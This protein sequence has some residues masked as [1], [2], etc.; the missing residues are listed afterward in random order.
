MVHAVGVL[1]VSLSCTADVLPKTVIASAENLAQSRRRLAENDARLRPALETLLAEADKA[2]AQGLV[3][4]V[5]DD[6]V[7][8]SGNRRDY[9]SVGPYWWPNPQT[10]DGLPYIRKD[11]E[12][13]PERNR[14][15]T[16][17]MGKLNGAVRSLCLAYFFVGNEAYAEHAA[18]LL[19]TWF[20]DPEKGMNPNLNYGQA[21]PGRCDGRGVGII[22]TA[23]LAV[24]VDVLGLLEL[25]PAWTVGDRAALEQWF[26]DYL[27]WLLTSSHGRDEAKAG[28][29][30]GTYYDIQVAVF[31]L[32]CGRRDVARRTLEQVGSRR[33]ASQVAP[34]GRQPHELARTKSWSYSIMN[35]NGLLTLAQLGRHV[36][37]DLWSFST[38]DGRGL[39]NALD[40][41]VG[42]AAPD[43]VWPHPQ[44]GS[45]R[46]Q[47]LL[48]AVLAGSDG[49]GDPA[50]LEVLAQMPEEPLR[51]HRL[52]LFH[53]SAA[54]RQRP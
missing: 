2:L 29:N 44:L 46:A 47:D 40:F 33:I 48:Q 32:F 31:A 5:D 50:F 35:L 13:N 41:M 34:D 53:P 26:S 14:G 43:A 52:M 20:L 30:H 54:S 11:G 51:G 1:A 38:P 37:V 18:K 39:R 23:S 8:P 22:D 4:V 17:A 24:L 3:S 19:R 16:V 6:L 27:D 49:F 36:G 28:N 12:V 45:R 10:K 15:D 7:P 25:S 42:F 9:M 21:I